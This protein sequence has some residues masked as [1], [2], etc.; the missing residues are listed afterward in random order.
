MFLFLGLIHRIYAE[1]NMMDYEDDDDWDDYSLTSYPTKSPTSSPT[2][3]YDDFYTI[4][5]DDGY[6][7][8]VQMRKIY[9]SS[10]T[11][12][13]LC[14][15]CTFFWILWLV[16]TIFPTKITHLYKTQG[17][18]VRGYVVESYV[19]HNQNDLDNMPGIPESE[20]FDLEGTYESQEDMNLPTYNAVVSYVVPGSIALGYRG[21]SIQ[22]TER[23]GENY[24]LHGDEKHGNEGLEGLSKHVTLGT[25]G[26]D[27]GRGS[28]LPPRDSKKLGEKSEPSNSSSLD[29]S[30]NSDHDDPMSDSVGSD[31]AVDSDGS[32]AARK[33]SLLDQSNTFD[34]HDKFWKDNDQGYYKYNRNDKSFYETP[35]QQGDIFEDD[36]ETIG[37]LFY[38]FGILK[39]KKIIR[40]TRPVRVK[41]RFETNELLE[42]GMSNVE[43]IVLP[44]NPG[45]GILKTDF[46]QNEVCRLANEEENETFTGNPFFTAMIGV[47]LIAVSVI[48]AV[49]GAL[50]LPYRTR[51]YGWTF[52]IVSLT[53]MW[54]L[55]MLLYKTVNRLRMYMMNKIIS[56]EPCIDKANL[57]GLTTNTRSSVGGENDFVI[58]LDR[59]DGG[60]RGMFNFEDASAISSIGGY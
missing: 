54:P 48:G 14:L 46:E 59:G 27:K 1:D 32:A 38:Q 44:G 19:T 18:V 13:I 39:P 2:R 55:A 41:K 29:A 33:K 21:R 16:G 37:N 5:E 60:K 50:N 47:I 52:V 20:S 40:D 6:T 51:V 15:L 36:P 12:V 10:L 56:F 49:H 11:D 30:H 26:H 58:M 7:A 4:D 28:S 34:S 9:F 22:R 3:G 8:E 35:S 31:G 23:I 43:I 42:A 57:Y 45:S 53:V 25:H 17:V 24:V